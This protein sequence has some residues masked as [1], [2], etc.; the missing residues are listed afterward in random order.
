MSRM[1]YD[2]EADL[3]TTLSISVGSVM[4]APGMFMFL[5]WPI[6]AVF[7]ALQRTQL[8]MTH[9]ANLPLRADL[10]HL[11][12]QIAV[13]NVDQLSEL[14]GRG[15]V[16]VGARDPVAIALDLPVKPPN[17]GIPCNRS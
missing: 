12:R 10:H 4:I 2:R 17:R 1:S 13:R 9:S 6:V 7:S 14:H 11:E 8:A 16:L 5:V 15:K 3:D